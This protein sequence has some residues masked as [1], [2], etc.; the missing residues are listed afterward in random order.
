MTDIK[1]R[2]Y[3]SFLKEKFGKPVYK[4]PINIDSNCPNRDGT[5]SYG[6]CIYCSLTGS[7]TGATATVSQQIDSFIRGRDGLYIPYFQSYSN[8]YGH[9][10]TLIERFKEAISHNNIVGI[11]IGTRPDTVYREI[12]EQIKKLNTFTQIELGLESANDSVLMDIN[13]HDTVSSFIEASKLVKSVIPDSHLVGHMI[14]G[15]PGEGE[16]DCLKTAKLIDAHCDGI[17]FHHLYIEKGMNVY[18]MFIKNQIEVMSQNDYMRILNNILPRLNNDIVIHRLK[19]SSRGS[20]LIAPLWTLNS[21]FRN[22]FT[23]FCKREK[24]KSYQ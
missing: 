2:T 20:K 24:S 16:D 17:K 19:S 7:G 10:E 21:N 3:S 8:M 22:D 12:L 4:I 11:S 5:K 1:Y 23:A 15:L 6:G 9:L 18:D 14:V 13:R